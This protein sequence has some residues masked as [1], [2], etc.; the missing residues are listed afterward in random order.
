MRARGMIASG[1]LAGSFR[2]G[3]TG[4]TVNL[5][6]TPSQVRIL[7]S[8]GSSICSAQARVGDFFFV[9]VL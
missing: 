5:L 9:P 8:P 7:H 3:Q 4:Q 2:S 1:S 6:A